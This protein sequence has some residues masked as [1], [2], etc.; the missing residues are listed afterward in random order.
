MADPSGVA[1]VLG[2]KLSNTI[3]GLLG[4]VVRLSVR[5]PLRFYQAAL[6]VVVAALTAAYATP[7]AK[8]YAPDGLA[9]LPEAENAFAFIVG[10]TSLELVAALFVWVEKFRIEQRPPPP[11]PGEH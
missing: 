5:P 3:A 7:F 2:I 6:T 1:A 9:T 8:H 11:P 4:G 10:L